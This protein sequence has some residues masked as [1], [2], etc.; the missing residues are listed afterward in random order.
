MYTVCVLIVYAA[1]LFLF[2][3][4]EKKYALK[5]QRIKENFFFYSLTQQCCYAA[6][7]C[8]AKTTSLLT[9]LKN[10]YWSAQTQPIETGPFYVKCVR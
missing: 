4:L 9:S 10:V 6:L 2:A 1:K 8:H 7:Q 5:S 3:A